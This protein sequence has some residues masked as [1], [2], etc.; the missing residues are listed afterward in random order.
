[1]KINSRLGIFQRPGESK[2]VILSIL[3]K[4]EE[5]VS[6]EIKKPPGRPWKTSANEDR[7]FGNESKKDWFATEIAL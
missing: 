5:T 6:C 4:L 2:S 7:W 3:R 1:M